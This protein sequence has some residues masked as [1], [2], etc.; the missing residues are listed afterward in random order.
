MRA[1][2]FDVENVVLDANEILPSTTF[3]IYN[4]V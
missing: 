3:R 1:N 2:I 4:Y